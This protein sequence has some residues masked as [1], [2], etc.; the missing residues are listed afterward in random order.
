MTTPTRE[1]VVQIVMQAHA[2]GLLAPGY[3]ES[4]A[5]IIALARAD[6]EATIAE[7]AAEISKLIAAVADH[8]TVRA[9]QRQK[10]TEQ[11]T[12]IAKCRQI[13]ANVLVSLDKEINELRQQLATEQAYAE[14]LRDAASGMFGPTNT[15]RDDR[16]DVLSNALSIPH[17]TTALQE[18]GAN[19]VD[20][21]ID[22]INSEYHRPLAHIPDKIRKGEF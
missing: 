2:P 18:Y 17:D 19:L 7:Q 8:V 12:E 20:R 1:Q 22:S 9:E 5:Q 4:L 10:I 21:V 3:S 15:L 16:Y 6:L 14:Q 11:A 13:D